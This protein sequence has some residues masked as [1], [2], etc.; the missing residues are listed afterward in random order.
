MSAVEVHRVVKSPR[1]RASQ[2]CGTIHRHLLVRPCA[3]PDRQIDVTQALVRAV[4]HELWRHEGG[5]EILNWLEAERVVSDL[6]GRVRA[7]A[8]SGRQQLA[9]SVIES[10]PAGK[11]S[12][13][14]L[15]VAA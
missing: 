2:G 14:R 4:A 15:R 7:A 5:N 12:T 1:R 11:A 6:L 10:K 9:H 13:A 8:G 3:A